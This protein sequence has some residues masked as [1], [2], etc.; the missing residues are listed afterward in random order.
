MVIIKKYLNCRFYDMLCSQ[1]VNMDYIKILVN[2]CIDF[3][4]VD[5]KFGD[6]VIK[7]ILLQIISELEINEYQ[8]LFM[9]KFFK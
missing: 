1:Y 2:E 5:L 3:N 9:N 4:V 8:L 7:I 6:D